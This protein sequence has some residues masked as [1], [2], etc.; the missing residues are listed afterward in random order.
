MD[1][2]DGVAF[3]SSGNLYIGDLNNNR[4]RA[5]SSPIT[6]GVTGPAAITPSGVRT[7]YA[8]GQTKTSFQR[9]DVVLYRFTTAGAS[10]NTIVPTTIEITGPQ[11]L[12]FGSFN[13][14]MSGNQDWV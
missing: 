12:G 13:L 5:I 11:D 14:T 6:G 10:G 2:A 8:A 4:I 3:D 7:T 9:G 1:T